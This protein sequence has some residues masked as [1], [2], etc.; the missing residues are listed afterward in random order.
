MRE[1]SKTVK[2][3]ELKWGFVIFFLEFVIECYWAL[4]LKPDKISLVHLLL[5]LFNWVKITT[6]KIYG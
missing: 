5:N 4:C 6:K 2:L 1:I 3:F